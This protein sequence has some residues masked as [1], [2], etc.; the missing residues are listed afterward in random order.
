MNWRLPMLRRTLPARTWPAIDTAIADVQRGEATTEVR[1]LAVLVAVERGEKASWPEGDA[2]ELCGW[3][4]A[5]GSQDGA[6]L[7]RVEQRFGRA[8]VDDVAEVVP[9]AWAALHAG[10]LDRA[11]AESR[12]LP[13]AL[14]GLLATRAPVRAAATRLTDRL[15]AAG[16]DI[17]PP[18]R[19]RCAE[20]KPSQRAPLL[21]VLARLAPAAPKVEPAD[22][23]VHAADALGRGDLPGALRALVALWRA[24]RDPALAD[25]IDELAKGLPPPQLGGKTLSARTTAWVTAAREADDAALIP[26]LVAPWPPEWR[27]AVAYVEALGGR[28]HP[29]IARRLVELLETGA[30]RSYQGHAF[31]VV[32]AACLATCADPRT[33][34]RLA[35][36]RLHD[37]SLARQRDWPSLMGALLA[38]RLAAVTRA[39]VDLAPLKAVAGAIRRT[40]T[41][42]LYAAVYANADDVD[43]RLVLADALTEAGDPRGAFIQLQCAA[44][45]PGADPALARRATTLLNANRR[46]WVP[47]QA[48]PASAAFER[49]FAYRAALRDSGSV[50][51]LA[52][53]SWGTVRELCWPGSGDVE[54]YQGVL[55]QPSLRALTAWH[56]VEILWPLRGVT[57]ARIEALSVRS[58][59][60]RGHNDFEPAHAPLPDFDG[61]SNLRHL[62]VTSVAYRVRNPRY[63]AESRAWG[64][65]ETAT[66]GVDPEWIPELLTL[67]AGPR[68]I[69]FVPLFYKAPGEPAWEVVYERVGDDLR[70]VSVRLPTPAPLSEARSTEDLVQREQALQ[71]PTILARLKP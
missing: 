37:E 54:S 48:N 52:H 20:L 36:L 68:R 51:L 12:A 42:E 33:A 16:V 25:W 57:A 50:Q 60:A 59:V 21:A 35:P 67:P 49:G 64:R 6:D 40:S 66:L 62:T 32:A 38:E 39:P 23:V 63:A 13:L 15:V 14:A 30:Y 27:T 61:L 19:A 9:F 8:L 24:T 7:A 69:R 31:S 47:E 5:L 28:E 44:A 10:W 3:V 1:F 53:P 2:S 58:P 71:L 70:P 34:G 18:L 11:P 29:V 56:R 45:E 17:A 22:A 65:L 43:A 46:A 41:A 4:M 55:D 26:L